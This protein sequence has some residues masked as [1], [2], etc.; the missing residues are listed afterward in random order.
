M[1]AS[2]SKAAL[3]L[4][5]RRD[6]QKLG[7]DI[8]IA[9]RRRRVPMGLMAERAFVSRNTVTRVERGDPAV[10]MGIY[11]TVL[12]VLG[13]SERLGR[14]ADSSAWAWT[15]SACPSACAFRE[16]TRLGGAVDRDLLVHLEL[17]GAPIPV[18][19]LWARGRGGAQ[20]AS[21]E[22]DR[23]WLARR[24]AFSLD[25][26]LPLTLGQFHT[27]RPLFNVFTDSAPDR[28]GQT[29][30]RRYYRSRATA[31]A[32]HPRT[33]LQVDFLTLVDDEARLGALRFKDSESGPFLSTTEGRRVP[34]RSPREH[35]IRYAAA[36]PLPLLGKL[37]PTARRND[38]VCSA[39]SRACRVTRGYSASGA[40]PPQRPSC[41]SP[42]AGTVAPARGP[43]MH[44]CRKDTNN[45]HVVSLDGNVSRLLEA[46]LGEGG[47]SAAA[48]CQC[49]PPGQSRGDR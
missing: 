31:Q 3:P 19:R 1:K 18:G 2:R 33:L 23:A 36:D 28:W 21:F 13:M 40:C 38:R 22:Y 10:S 43:A 25:P 47:R 20:S 17:T 37:A 39:P 9:R 48:R 41:M 29:L 45:W 15:R 42:D 8:S 14:M 4:S 26:E 7:E 5:V 11:A 30:L 16:G 44:A 12:F 49:L 46:N 32:R 35:G 27:E 6:L 24:D 34:D